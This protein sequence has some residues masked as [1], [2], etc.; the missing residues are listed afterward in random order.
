MLLVYFKTLAVL[1]FFIL[2]FVFVL[3]YY[4]SSNEWWEFTLG[5]FII[6][7]I[8]PIVIYKLWKG[9]PYDTKFDE[10]EAEEKDE[11]KLIFIGLQS[12]E[13]IDIELL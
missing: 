9:V 13:F 4:M 7:V 12:G 10:E 11:S 8:D 6:L 3:P 5:W 1:L 2:Q